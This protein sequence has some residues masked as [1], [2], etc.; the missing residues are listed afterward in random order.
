M[1]IAI[2]PD[3]F[4]GSMTA[5]EACTAIATGILRA[6][7]DAEMCEIPMADGGE[8]TLDSIV[9][10]TGGAIYTARVL[11]PIGVPVDARYGVTTDGIGVIEMAEASG[12]CLLKPEELNPLTADSVGTGQLILAALD[13]GCRHIILCI[14][15][16]ATNDGG[17]GM[18]GALG[19][20]LLDKNDRAIARGNAGLKDLQRIDI[21]NVD[22]RLHEC[23]FEVA[24]DVTNPL[25]GENGASRVFAPQKGASADMIP[26]LD[27][28]LAH[29]AHIV[30]RDLGV[31]ILNARGSGAAGGMGGAAM[32]F[33]GAK[34]RSGTDIVSDAVGLKEKLKD[35]DLVVTGE[36]RCDAQTL[37]GKAVSGIIRA[38]NEWRK[39]VLILAG[40]VAPDVDVLY[41][42]GVIGMFSILSEPMSLAEAME[43]GKVLLEKLAFR[44]LMCIEKTMRLRGT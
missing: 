42:R 28:N 21:K 30:S 26:I 34:L 32:A 2:A 11:N 12:L 38:A 37:R 13:R 17:N 16:S 10:A 6:L 36:G 9:D 20:N 18:A 8:G 22:P 7:P 29:L 5:K 33:L 19:F 15:G 35:V 25:C 44:T 39:P 14:G 40:S 23:S 3:S 43:K 31:D 24:C 41:E 27:A 1:K 4:K